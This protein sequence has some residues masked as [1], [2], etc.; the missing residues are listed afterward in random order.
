MSGRGITTLVLQ[1]GEVLKKGESIW[2]QNLTM[3]KWYIANLVMAGT[4]PMKNFLVKIHTLFGVMTFDVVSFI[5]NNT[6]ISVHDIYPERRPE[7]KF[8]AVLV[9]MKGF[10]SLL[11]LGSKTLKEFTSTGLDY[12]GISR[13]PLF[14]NDSLDQINLF[15]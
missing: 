6:L 10:H 8:T 9:K 2:Q 4:E 5:S 3:N 15:L 7:E 12:K 11:T 1:N 13:V 14:I